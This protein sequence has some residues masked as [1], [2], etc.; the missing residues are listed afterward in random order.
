M[1]KQTHTRIEVSS[2]RID[3]IVTF[4]HGDLVHMKGRRYRVVYVDWFTSPV[5]NVTVRLRR[6]P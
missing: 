5:K 2:E 3:E 6:E 1:P 4:Q